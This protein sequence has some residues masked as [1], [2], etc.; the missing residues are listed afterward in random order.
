VRSPDECLQI[1][2]IAMDN[3]RF[4]QRL[5]F[6]VLGFV[7]LAQVF[8]LNL[9]GLIGAWE[10]SHEDAQIHGTSLTNTLLTPGGVADDGGGP[11][12]ANGVC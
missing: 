11:K 4:L 2:D 6:F 5:L 12:R 9:H 3:V 10:A 8:Y 1:H 7:T